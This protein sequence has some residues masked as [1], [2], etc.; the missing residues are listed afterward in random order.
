MSMRHVFSLVVAQGDERQAHFSGSSATI[1][2]LSTADLRALTPPQVASTLA[3][4]SARMVWLSSI[5]GAQVVPASTG[6]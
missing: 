5:P 1:G 4:M 3:S 2:R 6:T